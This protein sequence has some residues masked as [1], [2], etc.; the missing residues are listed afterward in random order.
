MSGPEVQLGTR[1]QKLELGWE[2]MSGPSTWAGGSRKWMDGN[3]Y[4]KGHPCLVAP[5]PCP[6]H[7]SPP[8]AERLML[9]P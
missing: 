8:G 2:P 6:H 4:M 9:T 5:S 7:L 1:R 3:R